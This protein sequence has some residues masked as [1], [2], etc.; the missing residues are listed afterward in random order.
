MAIQLF[1]TATDLPWQL[2]DLKMVHVC[3]FDG[4][5]FY[6]PKTLGYYRQPNDDDFPMD[7]NKGFDKFIQY[8]LS[9]Y[10]ELRCLN[11]IM[12]L[13]E[14][15]RQLGQLDFCTNR[16]SLLRIMSSK[17]LKLVAIKFRG[18]IYLNAEAV[19]DNDIK[20]QYTYLFKLR[21]YLIVDQLGDMPNTD[22]PV[23]QNKQS[24]GTFTAKLG[25]FRLLYTSE[26]HGLE[27]TEPLGN[28]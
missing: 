28:L 3:A 5:E 1:S 15:K 20:K 19:P 24:Y 21:Q 16:G 6:T 18:C 10:S 8:S 7:L 12:Q 2:T 23:D 11:Y 14:P 9:F 26:I 13:P 27:N 22:R 25:K 17:Q 4:K